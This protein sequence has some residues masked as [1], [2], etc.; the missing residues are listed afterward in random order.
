[1]STHDQTQI[2]KFKRT[3]K[4]L[5]VSAFVVFTFI[6]YALHERLHGRSPW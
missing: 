1:M 4:K 6:A 5:S 2:S 3:V